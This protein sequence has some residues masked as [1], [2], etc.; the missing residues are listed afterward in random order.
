MKG[1]GMTLRWSWTCGFCLASMAA[2]VAIAGCRGPSPGQIGPSQSSGPGT[3][4]EG[5]PS[6]AGPIEFWHTRT[7]DDAKALNAIVEAFIASHPGTTIKATYQGNYSQLS[8]KI[9]AS[10][11]T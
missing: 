1:W 2:S 3:V 5:A 4:A 10:I 7:R 8:Q 9:T 11:Q 6:A